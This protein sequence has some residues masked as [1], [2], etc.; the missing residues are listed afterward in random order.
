MAREDRVAEHHHA[1]PMR[2]DV[3][4]AFRPR[5]LERS[6]DDLEILRLV[7]IGSNENPVTA[8]LDLVADAGL[9]RGATRRGGASGRS[10]STM[11]ASEVS[12]SRTAMEA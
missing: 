5:S 3:S 2:H 6:L 1:R 7:A 8:D 11:K 9:A 10:R 4:P 12:W